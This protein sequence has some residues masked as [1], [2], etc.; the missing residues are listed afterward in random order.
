[1]R[2]EKNVRFALL[3]GSAARGT[4]TQDSDIDVLVELR[5]PALDRV[6]DL[7]ER[8]TAA[9]GRPVEVVRLADT[10]DDP[11]FLSEVLSEGRVLADRDEVWST[12]RSRE[13]GLRRRRRREDARRAEAALAGIDRLLTG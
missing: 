6:V 3:F 10:D 12:L 7:G 8:L 11:S 13:P 1:L 4:D 2:T 5:D 9:S